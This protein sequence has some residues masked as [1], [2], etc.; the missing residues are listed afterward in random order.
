[1]HLHAMVEE[2]VAKYSPAGL[3]RSPVSIH[4][5]GRDAAAL[6]S[7][8]A[9]ADERL[10]ALSPTDALL[11]EARRTAL[12]CVDND[13]HE[14]GRVADILE[15]NLRAWGRP[16]TLTRAVLTAAGNLSKQKGRKS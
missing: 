2:F 16:E 3:L 9:R 15:R 7:A 14:P 1:M 10:K 4:G 11:V 6:L 13:V 12:L 8:A 5:F